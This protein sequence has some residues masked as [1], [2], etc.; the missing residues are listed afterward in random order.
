MKGGVGTLGGSVYSIQNPLLGGGFKYFLFSPLPG[1][2]SHFD[3]Y[4][5]KGV[6]TTNQSWEPTYPK[7]KAV[8]KMSFLSD[9][10][11]VFSFPG[12]PCVFFFVR[13]FPTFGVFVPK[14]LGD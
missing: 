13:K 12:G 4:F 14:V 1:E 6:E 11:D 10:W 7:T 5:S 2:D 9:W 8:R 3:S